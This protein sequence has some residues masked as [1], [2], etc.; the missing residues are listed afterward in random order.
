MIIT[1][2][3]EEAGRQ[4]ASALQFLGG[5]AH[6]RKLDVADHYQIAS[7]AE[8]ITAEFGSVNNARGWRLTPDRQGGRLRVRCH[9]P[10][11]I[12]GSP[13]PTW[14]ACRWLATP[15]KPPLRRSTRKGI[16]SLIE[17]SFEPPPILR[18][19]ELKVEW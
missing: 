11:L 16:R 6:F 1:D 12:R 9:Q 3:D 15:T 17:E 18:T 7:L 10:N 13:M 14:T 19:R 5:E 2:I 8:S 4:A